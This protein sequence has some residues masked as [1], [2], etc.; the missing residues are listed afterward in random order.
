[1]SE[2]W[3]TVIFTVLFWGFANEVTSVDEAKRFYGLLTFG[4]SIAGIFSGYA[5][6]NFSSNNYIP[7]IPYG[8][9][10]WD[11]SLFFLC[12]TVISCSLVTM[13]IFRYLNLKVIGP[14]EKTK[15]PK[16]KIKMS[17]RANFAYLARSKYLICI[18]L[19]VFAYNVA[20]NLIE[21]VWKDQMR[22][23][24]PNPAD[25]NVYMGKVISIMAF[26]ASL[27]GLLTTTRVIQ[28]Y[29]WSVCALIP[30]VL[31]IPNLSLIHI[32]EPTRPY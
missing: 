2:L 6:I 26:V 15:P 29:S 10:S 19:I 16:E 9:N 25:Y 8:Q 13:G 14:S 30:P 28:R 3:S 1:M 5:V 31:K 24:Y 32:S 11:Q 7:W 4:G 23:L 21:I 17:M 22:M 20:T 12:L 18:A 27:T